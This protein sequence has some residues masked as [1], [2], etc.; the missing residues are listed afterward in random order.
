MVEGLFRQ[1]FFQHFLKRVS[2]CSPRAGSYRPVCSELQYSGFS[3]N[4]S[5]QQE[6]EW[7]YQLSVL[8]HL[9]EYGKMGWCKKICSLSIHFLKFSF[10]ALL[11]NN[12]VSKILSSTSASD[13][14]T[15]QNQLGWRLCRFCKVCS[16]QE[17]KL[18]Y[19]TQ[20]CT[21]KNDA[22]SV[23]RYTLIHAGIRQ[24]DVRYCER[25]LL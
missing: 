22:V 25:A 20:F 5:N 3:I 8:S 2:L 17:S 13:A 12:N 23:F 15:W 19:D 18:T 6:V 7:A 21:G 9:D 1:V 14:E 24:A 4:N 10:H 11:K 16:I